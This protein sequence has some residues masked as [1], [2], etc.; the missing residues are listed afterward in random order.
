MRP[1]P[2]G[3]DLVDEIVSSLLKLADIRDHEEI[4]KVLD[5]A[6]WKLSVNRDIRIELAEVVQGEDLLKRLTKEYQDL[7]VVGPKPDGEEDV[8]RYGRARD[9]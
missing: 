2:D 6:M 8:G 5:R 4:R 1:Y 3:R 9:E 7:I